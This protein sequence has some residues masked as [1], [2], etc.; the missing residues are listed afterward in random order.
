MQA[1]SATIRAKIPGRPSL[2][3]DVDGELD[4][5]V[6]QGGEREGHAAAR[7]AAGDE[8]AQ[9][10]PRGSMRGSVS[11]VMRCLGRG[12]A[13]LGRSILRIMIAWS[14]LAASAGRWAT[15]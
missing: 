3:I 12:T 8:T 4:E 1:L 13:V 2:S 6:G 11:E 7:L 15:S 10:L 14:T 9:A 5:R